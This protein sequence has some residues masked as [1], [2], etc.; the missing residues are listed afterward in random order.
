M[1]KSIYDQHDAAFSNV[2]AYVVMKGAERVATIA[3]KYPRD[4]ASR[5]YVYVHYF[6]QEMVRGHANGY[7]YGYDK[8]SAA[9]AN[10]GNKI[11][12]GDD[13]SAVAFAA[14]LRDGDNGLGWERA[15]NGSGFTVL[16]AV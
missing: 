2:S 12:T 16:Q 4:G 8:R 7:G 6:G 13:A 3:F 14:A 10:A 1:S 15:L 5:L 11:T 9:I